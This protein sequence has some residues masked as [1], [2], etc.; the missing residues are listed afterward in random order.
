MSSSC[1]ETWFADLQIFSESSPN[2]NFCVLAISFGCIQYD[3][4]KNYHHILAA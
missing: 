2:C 3:K 4:G 1:V